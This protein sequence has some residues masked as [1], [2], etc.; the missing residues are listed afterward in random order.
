M[1]YYVFRKNQWERTS[2]L[3][4]DIFIGEKK[5]TFRVRRK[6][7]FNCPKTMRLYTRVYVRKVKGIN[8]EEGC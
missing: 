8:N 7:G 5:R 4:Y 6:N 2:K 3:Y 1:N